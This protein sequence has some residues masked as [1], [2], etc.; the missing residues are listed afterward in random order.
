[1][2]WYLGELHGNGGYPVEKFILKYRKVVNDSEIE[3]K[4]ID[5]VKPN[6]SQ[7]TVYQLLPNTT[8]FFRIQAVNRL[9]AVCFFS[10]TCNM[11]I[12]TIFIFYI[13]F[14]LGA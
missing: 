6:A 9:G 3:W 14:P 4:K 12:Y 2:F 5:P 7:V 1:M 8:Y 11:C 10:L 13:P